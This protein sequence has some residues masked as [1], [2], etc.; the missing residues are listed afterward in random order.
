M[1]TI[2]F[3]GPGIMGG[4]MIANLVKA[5]HTV[6]ALGRSEASWRRVDEAGAERA[7][8]L[9][10]VASGAEVVI[11]ML[12]DGPD[13][14]AAVLGDKGDGAGALAA[15]LRSGQVLVDMSTISPA[16]SREIAD[17][18]GERGVAAL[19]A[20]VSG[21]EAGAIEGTLSIMVGGE[22][23]VLDG[24]RPI[25]EVLGNT[26]THVGPAG[27]GQLTKAANQLIVATNI[28]AVAE[29]IV[30]L[31]SAGVDLAAA[32]SAIGG[33]L[34]GSTVLQ[35]KRDA[36]LTGDF[37]P[38]FRIALHDKDLGIVAGAVREQGLSLP[39]TALITQLVAALRARGDGDLDHS[40]LLKLAREL[41]G[42]RR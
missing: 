25:L 30:F 27:S 26:I 9:A 14:R 10:A 16:V 37:K 42:M 3:V 38:G 15:V 12:P 35:R 34:A 5:G 31:E 40:A 22:A 13:V 6:R 23:A 19:D 8:D 11:T 36:F 28:G 7:S 41:N 39:V 21:G 18:L 29:A 24:V 20:P 17:V 2:G 33:G 4:P 1:T 32:L